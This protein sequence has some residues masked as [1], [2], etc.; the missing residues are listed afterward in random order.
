[1][2]KLGFAIKIANEGVR[3]I[4]EC[5]KGE[6]S[7]KVVDIR[8]YLKFFSGL[9]GTSNAVMFMSFDKSGCFLTVFRS[10]PGRVGDFSSAWIYIPNSIKIEA[11]YI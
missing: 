3:S 8:E 10:I 1:M 9:Q 4:I 7:N 6:W 2:N 11:E 5:N